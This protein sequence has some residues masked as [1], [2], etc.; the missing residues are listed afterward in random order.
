M[1]PVMVRIIVTASLVAF[2][3]DAAPNIVIPN[4][5]DLTIKTRNAVGKKMVFDMTWSFKGSRQRLEQQ[6]D[7]DPHFHT[8]TLTE[9]DQKALY[10]LNE[11][12]KTYF[13]RSLDEEFS[14]ERDMLSGS[15][16]G[17]EVVVTTE[18]VDTGERRQVGSF[19]ARHIKTTT[20]MDPSEE[21]GIH[22]TKIETDGWYIDLP[23]RDCRDDADQRTGII[24]ASVGHRRPRF[25]FR[26]VGTARRGFPIE[27]L[28]KTTRAGDVASVSK[29]ELLNISERPLDAS[30]F[31]VP[32]G[33]KRASK[34][35]P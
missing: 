32:P 19:E 2:A 20:T 5:R 16:D 33:F 23:G 31:E 34:V 25:V 4:F 15:A 24:T 11:G 10:F 1:L 30:L 17:A 27:E 35:E 13:S 21:T 12:S 26:Q 9:C 3:A 6:L 28:S 29:T 14:K 18:S 8:I 22:P 7:S